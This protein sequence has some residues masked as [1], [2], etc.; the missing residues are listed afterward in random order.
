MLALT[1]YRQVSPLPNVT[2]HG[3][4]VNVWAVCRQ[5]YLDTL[6]VLVFIVTYLSGSV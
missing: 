5:S 6:I 4:A 1:V 3:T 2:S